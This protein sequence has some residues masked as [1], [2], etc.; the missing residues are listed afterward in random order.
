MSDELE[1]FE[2][3]S[4]LT[5]RLRDLRILTTG[6]FDEK[7][8][9]R[10]LTAEILKHKP[11]AGGRIIHGNT[12]FGHSLSL[13]L[14]AGDQCYSPLDFS[15]LSEQRPRRTSFCESNHAIKLDDL[16]RESE[17]IGELAENAISR[18][19]WEVG[20]CLV[21]NF[22]LF[23]SPEI[24]LEYSLDQ[25]PECENA[26]EALSQDKKEH[27]FAS[28]IKA[29]SKDL[30]SVLGE[31]CTFLNTENISHNPDSIKINLDMYGWK[32]GYARLLGVQNNLKRMNID[33]GE[34][35]Q[36][37]FLVSFFH[38]E[39]T[40]ASPVFDREEMRSSVGRPHIEVWE[41]YSSNLWLLPVL[42]I[43]SL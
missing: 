33:P 39:M 27:F 38:K 37:I 13:S 11:C 40:S 19:E 28:V 14:K 41:D 20:R 23:F 10:N 32:S 22:G 3:D 25:N 34:Y 15:L 42:K 1:R 18:L 8:E 2:L 26:I 9:Y 24:M 5:Q 16:S 29:G 36:R 7:L 30:D 43:G 4:A 17:L 35:R 31:I 12:T 21:Y 6:V